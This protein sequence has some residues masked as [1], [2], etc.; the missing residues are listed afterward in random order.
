[1]EGVTFEVIDAG[2]ETFT[3]EESGS[4]TWWSMPTA[5]EIRTVALPEGYECGEET[6]YTLPEEGGVIEITLNRI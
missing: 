5:C 4:V 1:V 3:T 2:T 6:V